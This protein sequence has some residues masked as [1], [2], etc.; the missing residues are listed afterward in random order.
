MYFTIHEQLKLKVIYLPLSPF[1]APPQRAH[2][3][4]GLDN[5]TKSAH[6]FEISLY[7]PKP[8]VQILLCAVPAT[9]NGWA[10]VRRQQVSFY[11]LFGKRQNIQLRYFSGSCPK[12]FPPP[13]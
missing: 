1:K 13:I 10:V 2:G 6:N 11:A 12:V 5:N 3:H 7:A 9:A 4:Q 8:L